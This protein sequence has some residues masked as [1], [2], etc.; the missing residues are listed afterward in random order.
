ME[1]VDLARRLG[2]RAADADRRAGL[3]LGPAL[4]ATSGY[5]R[6]PLR[7]LFCLS[8]YFAGVPP[9]RIARLYG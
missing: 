3:R 4:P 9:R 1:D 7:N 6:R 8:L 5:I 2:R